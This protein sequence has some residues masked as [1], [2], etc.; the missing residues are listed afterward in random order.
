M[1]RKSK[2]PARTPARASSKAPSR[3][4]PAKASRSASKQADQPLVRSAAQRAMASV[5][6]AIV[7]AAWFPFH[8]RRA[9]EWTA[10]VALVAAMSGG[11]LYAKPKLMDR[12]ART[13]AEPVS[14]HLAAPADPNN[15]GQLNPAIPAEVV[16]WLSNMVAQR[17][18]NDAFSTDD[19]EAARQALIATGWLTDALTIERQP[20]GVV[21]VRGPWRRPAAVVHDGKDR[22]L[23]ATDSAPLRVPVGYALRGTEYAIRNPSQPP[24]RRTGS[25]ENGW[26]VEIAFGQPWPGADVKAAIDLL[27][28]IDQSPVRAQVVGVDLTDFAKDGHLVLVSD[29]GS[30]IVWGSPARPD[31]TVPAG[32]VAVAERLRRMEAFLQTH[33]RIDAGYDNLLIY[34]STVLTTPSGPRTARP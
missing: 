13:H 28:L 22:Y 6:R 32:E 19:L 12:I 15:P 7:A 14:V 27:A 9:C 24:P 25:A 23:V 5:G 30:R 21:T 16:T 8:S 18:T 11:W 31:G 10:T 26:P 29:S 1:A 4:A 3:R 17:V 34:T 20:R 33:R 2:A